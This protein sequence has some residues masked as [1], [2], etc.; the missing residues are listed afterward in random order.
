MKKYLYSFAWQK[1][2]YELSRLEMRTF[3]NFHVEGN[4][5]MSQRKV[6][7]SRS[8]YMRLR[9]DI[10]FEG[11][12]FEQLVET[13]KQLQL[14]E[15][16]FK[17][18]CLNNS[19]DAIEPTL[20]RT[21]RNEYMLQLSY[22]IE[23]EPDLE[24]P[25]IVLG[26]GIH[27]GTF[28]LGELVA[29]ESV[30]LKHMQKP[31]MY[32]TALSTRDARAIVNISAPYPDGLKIIDPC[33]GIGTVLVEAMSMGI[34]IEGRDMN[35]R[36]VW[37]SRIN[38]RHFGYEPNV[39]IGPIEEADEGYDVAIIDMPYNLFTHISS[40]L[41]QSIITNARRIA[42]RVVIVTIETMDDKIHHANL[43][44]KDRAVLKK[45]KFERQVLICE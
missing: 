25:D 15:R 1:D 13:A 37:G 4:V 26:L 43:T 5:L 35:K 40:E 14:G 10:L 8:P 38:L 31:E 17:I 33:C 45:G 21:I 29:G 24:E 2:E 3:F 41:Q 42:K 12:T 18:H 7:P 22:A 11:N 20:N 19:R 6:E 9:L 27:D 30:W 32:S 39:E 23:A 34:N 44:I 16:T 28:Y 36:V